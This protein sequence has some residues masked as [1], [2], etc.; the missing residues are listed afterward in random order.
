MTKVANVI[1]YML[2]KQVNHLSDKK[3]AIMLFLIDFNHLKFCPFWKFVLSNLNLK[4][5]SLSF[6]LK[7]YIKVAITTK[8]TPKIIK[9]VPKLVKIRYKIKNKIDILINLLKIYTI[10]LF[11]IKNSPFN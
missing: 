6:F 4:L 8:I 9:N 7:L 11:G 5:F 3:V 10:V 2:H 1:L